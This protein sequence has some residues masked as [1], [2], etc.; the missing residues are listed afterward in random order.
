[1]PF[2]RALALYVVGL[3]ATLLLCACSGQTT[4]HNTTTAQHTSEPIALT[5]TVREQTTH[6]THAFTQGWLL[7]GD[8]FIESS[9]L[10]GQSYLRAYNRENKPL[11]TYTLPSDWFAEGVTQWHNSLFV[12]SW[13]SGKALELDAS[14]WQLR[15]TH[16]YL[17]EGW[18]L[19]HTEQSLI[20]SNGSADLQFRNPTTFALER[21]LKVHG[22]L[23]EWGN[24]NELEYAHGLIWANVWQESLIIAISPATGQVLGTLDLSKLVTANTQNPAYESLNGIAY[25]AKHHAFWVTGKLWANRYLIEI[26][27]NLSGLTQDQTTH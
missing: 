8:T 19:T 20:M 7:I 10:Y 1:M 9:G 25:D 6:S 16:S 13:Q 5:F 11:L 2:Y 17:G 22:G 15:R 24:L 12:L 23:R 26:H 18:G 14:N 27:P 4:T 3:I 21:R